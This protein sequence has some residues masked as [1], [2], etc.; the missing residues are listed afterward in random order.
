MSPSAPTE[1]I[2]LAGPD[3]AAFAQ[4]QFS[5]D[6]AALA[7]GDSQLNAWLNPQGRVR[8]LFHLLRA[9]EDRY[10][11]LLRGGE[12]APLLPVLKMFVLR[13]KARLQALSGWHWAEVPADAAV[14]A[15]AWP[16]A[17]PDGRLLLLRDGA[18]VDGLPFEQ[19]LARDIDAGLPWL[20]AP[21]LEQLLPSWMEFARLGALSHHKGCYPGQEIV[22]RLHFRGGGDKRV[23]VRLAAASAAALHEAGELRD[24]AGGEAGL[25]L[26]QVQ[27]P[28]GSGLAL[29]VV[30][31]ELAAAGTVLQGG[32]AV[33]QVLPP[34][35]NA[36][37]AAS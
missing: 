12:A 21:A 2:E 1:L 10:L 22:A 28:D 16:I 15:G 17:L 26:Q 13:L 36:P 3:A 9:D 6:V 20:P 18:A 7:I 19:T 24:A 5:N 34:T 37:A 30:R 31:R 32:E 14:P 4:A 25:L 11:L 33:L 8:R 29:A 27:M 35:W 23:P